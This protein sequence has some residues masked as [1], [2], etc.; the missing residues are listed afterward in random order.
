[1]EADELVS[2]LLWETVSALATIKPASA[3][4]K[5][6]KYT[7]IPNIQDQLRI[8]QK[9]AITS[10][11]LEKNLTTTSEDNHLRKSLS[12]KKGIIRKNCKEF[13][14]PSFQEFRH[15]LIVRSLQDMEIVHKIQVVFLSLAECLLSGRMVSQ[16]QLDLGQV[17]IQC[18]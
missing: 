5:T 3:W 15:F 11:L 7:P 14:D 12:I 8:R 13:P 2:S 17:K 4:V 1:M 16:C 6:V 9:E 18:R 10:H